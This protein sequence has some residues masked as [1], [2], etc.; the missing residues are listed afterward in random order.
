MQKAMSV[1]L[2]MFLTAP[3]IILGQV[4][5]QHP[6]EKP[7]P[8]WFLYRHA[9][10]DVVMFKKK[11]DAAEQQGIDRSNLRLLVA[12][13]GGLDEA[14]AKILEAI[15]VQCEKDVA[16]QDAKAKVIINAFRAQH[17]FGIVNKTLPI[18]PPPPELD[19]L[20][21][22]RIQI[23]LAARDQLRNQLGEGAF[24]K[25]DQALKEKPS[26]AGLGPSPVYKK[27]SQTSAT[28]PKTN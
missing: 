5:V 23:I 9:F 18:A 12:Q 6:Q 17:P 1:F 21:Q 28:T 10:H 8:E 22:Q 11:A 4:P 25:F 15:A 16:A 24:G 3:G 20:W 13:K 2:L 26:S 14:Q 7:L 19:S 27:Y